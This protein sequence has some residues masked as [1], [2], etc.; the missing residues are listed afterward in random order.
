MQNS[1]NPAIQ[2]LNTNTNRP[3]ESLFNTRPQGLSNEELAR[4]T[5][6]AIPQNPQPVQTQG[7]TPTWNIFANAAGNAGDYGTSF[8][9]L[10]QNRGQ[11]IPI[12]A[13]GVGQALKDYYT[14]MTYNYSNPL[15]R[16]AKGAYDAYNLFN[17]FRRSMQWEDIKDVV[18]GKQNVG[19]IVVRSALDAYARPLDFALDVWMLHDLG[20]GKAAT[21]GVKTVA[22][23]AINLTNKKVRSESI[24]VA[25]SAKGF[26]KF[27]EETRANAIKA[28][29]TGE[30]VTDANTK[31]ALKELKKLSNSYDELVKEF[32]PD[33]WIPENILTTNQRLV[34]IGKASSY[35]EAE[36]MTARLFNDA[37][38]FKGAEKA[39]DYGEV[40]LKQGLAEIEGRTPVRPLT[41]TLAKERTLTKEGEQ[42]LKNLAKEGDDIAG[43]VLESQKLYNKGWLKSVPHGLA[44]VDTSVSNKLTRAARKS[45]ADEAGRFAERVYGNATY[46]DIAKQ[47][48][49]TQNWLENKA[50]QLVEKE[51]GREI[52]NSGTIG[53]VNIVADAAEKGAKFLSRAEIEDSGLL[54]ALANAKTVA[55]S[56][57]DIPISKGMYNALKD[58]LE[59]SRSSNPFPEGFLR[60]A[61]SAGKTSKL[62]SGG[63]LFGNLITAA[64]NLAMDNLFN[65][66]TTARALGE[67]I[68][69]KGQLLKEM[70][71]YRQVARRNPKYSNDLIKGY[72][73][74]SGTNTLSNVVNYLDAKI[75]NIFAEAAAHTRLRRE[76]IK[77]SDRLDQLSLMDSQK[78]ADV[79]RHTQRVGNLFTSKSVVPKA[80]R[81]PIQLLNPFW[82]WPDTA[83]Q[84]AR[85]MFQQHPLLSYF[86]VM[87]V[88]PKI[89]FDKEMQNRANLNVQSD[90][91]FVH[92]RQNP[93]TGKIQEVTAEFM[94]LMNTLRM[95]NSLFSGDIA[96][97]FGQ[98]VPTLGAIY[99]AFKGV[100]AY[101]RPLRRAE[102]S[103][104]DINNMMTIQNGKRYK[105]NPQTGGFTQEVGGMGDEIASVILKET[106]GIPNFINKTAMPVYAG[107][108]GQTYYQPYGGA[109]LGTLNR[110][111]YGDVPLQSGN[112]RAG[113]ST[114][115]LMD[116]ISGSY[117]TDYYPERNYTTAGFNRRV[118]RGNARRAIEDMNYMR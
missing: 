51:L 20:F 100:D 16:A 40:G 118:F 71:I 30:K 13:K 25:D 56:A 97:A 74:W 28:F 95:T 36:K 64:S 67:A 77:F 104:T 68:A 70:G 61:T 60:D 47:L 5:I 52:I 114:Q 6:A 58:Q 79:I 73:K 3:V 55:S 39:A 62:S 69:S 87:D 11:A 85:Y 10:W 111:G 34:D 88:L 80:L 63:Y 48:V 32:S 21:K 92:Y 45:R 82:R 42:I 46:E 23:D 9:Y 90:K 41:N 24:K 35:A 38:I 7:Y 33:T 98:S 54:P 1:I 29:Q 66:I 27:S 44:E 112:P 110:A 96:G 12:I 57:D 49:D 43:E 65:P 4:Q 37:K 8:N 22:E 17:P 18:R 116:L 91:P 14:D 94:P 113:R 109:L 107:L 106:T 15:E 19:D 99:G 117:A 76:G 101:G 89:G 84:S 26:A 83:F 53:G 105:W 81:Q 59:L 108:T 31:S 75:Q 102:M 78:L 2:Y 115:E 72:M 86:V 93:R 103:S 50:T